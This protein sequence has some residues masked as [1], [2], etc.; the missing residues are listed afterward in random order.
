[1]SPVVAV[2]TSSS[3]S[4]FSFSGSPR[5]V[6]RC[7]V[8]RLRDGVVLVSRRVS[9]LASS[10]GDGL[11]PSF[12]VFLKDTP[13]QDPSGGPASDD[14]TTVVETV[15]MDLG[16]PDG[17]LTTQT[18]E[19]DAKKQLVTLTVERP[20]GIV[21]EENAKGEVV[22]V[23]V[24]EGNGK[25]AG[26]KEGDMLRACSCIFEVKGKVDELAFYGKSISNQ[27]FRGGQTTETNTV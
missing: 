3:S 6:P 11:E 7:R 10:G 13:P 26:V 18:I 17:S 5:R 14:A 21:F 9:V 8:P 20:L 27:I 12:A 25:S 2:R 15:E 19:R 4:S 1:M 16:A 22:A 24:L 23:E